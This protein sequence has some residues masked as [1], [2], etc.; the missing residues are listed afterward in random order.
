MTD[1]KTTTSNSVNSGSIIKHG[2][3]LPNPQPE[4]DES[5]DRPPW[6]VFVIFL[7][8][9][10]VLLVLYGWS[11]SSP[12]LLLT[13][14]L[15]GAA[16][17]SVGSLLGFLFGM[18]RA[19]VAPS[20][21]EETDA[22]AP[23]TYRPST[24]LEQVS[25][26][27]TKILIGVG[28]VELR[29]IGGTLASMGRMVAGSL[30]DAPPGT[31]VVTQ[32]VIVAFLIFGFI[33]SF[34]W[35]RIYYGPLQTIADVNLTARLRSILKE[36]DNRISNQES[37]TQNVETV[38]KLLATG[39]LVAPGVTPSKELSA[40]LEENAVQKTLPAE[41]L[42]KLAKFQ[43]LDED[44]NSDPNPQLFPDALQEVNGR[45]LEAELAADLKDYLVIKLRVRWLSG[46]PLNDRVVFLLHPTFKESIL[47]K[48]PQN[49]MAEIEIYAEGW[50]TVVAILDEGKTI[51]SYSL[52][53]LPNAPA[54]FYEG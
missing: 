13:E 50:F 28:L 31:E 45:R 42:D 30:K 12:P 32:V 6:L 52:K 25:D 17:I 51:L 47:Y 35:T 44:W 3:A 11:V 54:W 18:P 24:N 33:A 9:A 5:H 19:M 22:A 14:L 29:Q 2:D 7:T 41:I 4:A 20:T 8:T 21:S 53:N 43:K 46:E 27:L 1:L 15:V 10:T 38:T 49:G 26:W 16:S 36:L 34:L 37:A 48:K 23:M 39:K 40:S